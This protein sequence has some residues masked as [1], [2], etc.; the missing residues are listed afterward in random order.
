MAKKSPK[1]AVEVQS[2]PVMEKVIQVEQPFVVKQVEMTHYA[3]AMIQNENESYSVIKIGFNPKE[4]CVGSK[5]EV[6]ETNTDKYIIQER[7]SVLLFEMEY[8]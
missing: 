3:L 1:P 5:I 8:S 4:S 7:L 6:I 2:E